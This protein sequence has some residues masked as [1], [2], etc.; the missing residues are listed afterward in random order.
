MRLHLSV[1]ALLA[2]PAM[3]ENAPRVLAD[4]GPVHSLVAMVMEGVGEPSLV[5]PPGTSPHD[6]ALRPSD[7]AALTEADLIVWTGP[8]MLPWLDTAIGSL[9]PEAR[10][11]TL[12]ETEGWEPLIL[13]ARADGADPGHGDHDDHGD[14]GEHEDHNDHDDH[15]H[16]GSHDHEGDDH[17]HDGHHDHAH[18][19]P[20]EIDPHAWLDPAVAAVWVGAIAEALSDL[21]PAHAETYR[22]NAEAAQARLTELAADLRARMAP[23]GDRR[24]LAGHDAY[25]YFE[26]ASGLASAGSVADFTGAPPSPATIAA[27]RDTAL[28]GGASCLLLDSET[29]PAW[30]TTLGEGADLR[31]A[32]ADPEGVFLE[33]GPDL[34]PALIEGLAAALEDCLGG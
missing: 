5:V 15:A 33:P 29:D 26:R 18:G 32:M 1:L 22:S 10:I 25:A 27:L 17:G 11:L 13:G 9:A 12:L 19:A 2:T 21:D 31:T 30:A 4:I 14:H 6:M 8:V 20:G 16:D 7:A 28:S 3:A 23:L 34:Y 24:F